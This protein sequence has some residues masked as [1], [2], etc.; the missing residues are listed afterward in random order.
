MISLVGWSKLA[1]RNLVL[2]VILCKTASLQCR[3]C[4]RH[5][6]GVQ[7]QRRCLSAPQ[8][9]LWILRLSSS[10]PPLILGMTKAKRK[11]ACPSSLPRAAF[12]PAFPPS[13]PVYNLRL[14]RSLV[15]PI[16]SL[17]IMSGGTVFIAF[18][19]GSTNELC[20]SGD[21]TAAAPT[22][23]ISHRSV[24]YTVGWH[25]HCVRVALLVHC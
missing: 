13:T 7:T 16:A 18:S 2:Q 17:W 6:H 23:N 4:R 8:G 3:S 22:V 21:V 9:R 20:I 5:P 11:V 14:K 10:K 15:Q 24:A 25:R 12:L 19:L 1:N